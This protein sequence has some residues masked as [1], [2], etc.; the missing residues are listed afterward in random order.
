MLRT[1][2]T[3]TDTTSPRELGDHLAFGHGIHYCLG[4]ALARLEAR[5]AYDAL[6]AGTSRL[7]PAGPAQR[8][9]SLALRGFT[10]LPVRATPK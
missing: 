8:V 7:A 4:A 1:S 10:S 2:K 9:D 3:P 6:I 5:A